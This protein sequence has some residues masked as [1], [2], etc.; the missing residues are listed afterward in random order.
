MTVAEKLNI[1]NAVEVIDDG[2]ST[3]DSFT[4]WVDMKTPVFDAMT[5]LGMSNK[6]IV[7]Y[8]REN[9]DVSDNVPYLDIAPLAFSSTVGAGWYLKNSGFIEEKPER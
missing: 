4:V 6:Q 1:L 7:E 5:K 2:C 8:A 9:F 3:L